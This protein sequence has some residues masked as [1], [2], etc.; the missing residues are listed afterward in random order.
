ML[1]LILGLQL[2]GP[3]KQGVGIDSSQYTWIKE[4]LDVV[5][6]TSDAR[7]LLQ[8]TQM[9][10]YYDRVF[11]FALQ[12]ELVVLPKNA[13]PVD[14]AYGLGSDIGNHC[15]SAKVNGCVVPLHHVLNNGDQVEIITSKSSGPSPLW[16]EFV[17]TGKARAE[18]RDF[19]RMQQKQEYIKLGKAIVDQVFGTHAINIESDLNFLDVFDKESYD[20]LYLSI[21]EGAISMQDLEL[22]LINIRK[23]KKMESTRQVN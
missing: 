4:L 7:D 23:E 15:A 3:Y 10:M 11:C 12:G 22:L 20:N 19:V 6:K 1:L 14:F 2:I 8:N 16:E 13:T 18:I 21:G 5:N 9:A 17:V